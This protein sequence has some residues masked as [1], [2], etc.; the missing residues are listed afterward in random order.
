MKL[1]VL[2]AAEKEVTKAAVW[3]DK[4]QAG[5]G[6]D[7][8]LEYERAVSQI[9]MHPLRYAKLETVKT[10]RDIRQFFLHRF[11]YYVVYELVSDEIVV[12]AVSHSARR[13]NYW[14]RRSG[15]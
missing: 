7:F 13:P 10:A 11:P 12:L 8:F 4:R 15:G 14:L 3:Y 5:L 9:E 6:T 1:R 2:S